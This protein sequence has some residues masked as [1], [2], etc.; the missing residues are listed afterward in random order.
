MK[1]KY[2][3]KEIEDDS[4]FCRFCGEKVFRGRQKKEEVKVPKPQ[5]LPSGSYRAN[6][7]VNGERISVTEAT[8]SAYYVKARALKSGLLK[9]EKKTVAPTLREVCNGYI[10]IREN[11][12]SPSTV[13]GYRTIVK[14][15]YKGYMDAP[16]DKIDYQK[17]I[18]EEASMGI[19]PKT[20]RNSWLF[21]KCCLQDKGIKVPDLSTPQVVKKDLPWLDYEQIQSFL[22]NGIRGYSCEIGALLCLHGLRRSEALAVTK[23]KVHDGYIH[24]EGAVVR[25]EDGPVFKETNK[26]SSSRRKVPVLIPRLQELVDTIPEEDADKPLIQ[27]RADNLYDRINE[28]CDRAGVPKTGIHGLRRSFV[29]LCYHLKLS[30]METMKLGGYNDFA[31][32]RTIYTKL[33]AQDESEGIRKLKEFFT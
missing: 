5:K 7:M 6:I 29:S 28:A 9:I 30:E 2:C 11:I 12:L 1:C 13:R 3:K 10:D 31:T 4:L 22:D 14:T 20:I 23:G 16:A 8:E 18:N 21:I 19:S 32:M 25:S 27:M 17:M 26:N 24:V 15:R 33:S